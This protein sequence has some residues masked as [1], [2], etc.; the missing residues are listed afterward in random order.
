MDKKVRQ[1]R[2]QKEVNLTEQTLIII[3]PD[4]VERNLIGEIISRFE[5]KGF[6]FVKLQM[7]SFTKAMAE[8]FYSEHK[9]KRFFTELVSFITSGNVV[10]AVIEGENVITTTRLMVGATKSFEA[11]PGSIRGDLGL[12]ITNNI[13]HASDSP[14]SFEKEVNVV[15]Q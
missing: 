1:R 10:V 12:G 3:K 8:K 14:Q 4:A 11:A 6:K 2:N 7:L 15:F 9:D 5:N 13:I